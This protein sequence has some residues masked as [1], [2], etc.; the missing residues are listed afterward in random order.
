[1]RKL[2]LIA[3]ILLGLIALISAIHFSFSKPLNLS[4]NAQAQISFENWPQL[5]HDSAHTGRT[6]AFV[7]PNYE[8]A[9]VWLDKNHVVKN[10]VSAPGASITDNLPGFKYGNL[11][12][13]QVQPIVANGKVFFG[14][15]NGTV[16]AVNAATGDNLWDH[17]TGGPILH[18]LA[19]DSGTVVV[20]SMDGKV[21][22]LDENTGAEKWTYQT[23]APLKAAPVINNGTVYIGS[24]D[25]YFYA[26][27]ISNGNLKWKYATRVEPADANSPFNL[28][29]VIAPAAVSEDGSTVFFGAENTYFY[30]LNTSDG[31]E[32]WAPKKLVGQSFKYSWPVVKGNLVIIRPMSSLHEDGSVMEGVLDSMSADPSWTEEKAT[33]SAYLQA[34]PQQKSIYLFNIDTGQ[35]PYQ[36]AMGRLASFNEAPVPPVIDN[37]NR[38]LMFW[39]SKVATFLFNG[40]CWGTKYCPDMSAMD[41]TTGDRMKLNNTNTSRFNVEVD[42]VFS[43]TVGG[44]YLY[45]N[46][47]WRGVSSIRFSDGNLTRIEIFAAAFDCAYARWFQI[48][49]YGND[50]AT[51]CPQ[52]DPRAPMTYKQNTSPLGSGTVVANIAGNNMLF[53]NDAMTGAIIGIRHKP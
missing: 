49:L 45:L 1:M 16:F 4:S 25:G 34:N 48:V 33:M 13:R 40:S 52:A 7:D 39:R 28:A 15:M 8:A 51:G 50:T 23:G 44:D 29:P 26:L 6:A 24:Q 41:L 47:S 14:D 32:K 27:D 9:W 35:E 53:V 5:Q 21:Y 37:Q 2:S 17:P 12:A 42:N 19:Y 36:V 22:A 18:T 31:S 43:T 11:I 38:V 3:T 10:F 30:A 46:N 20:P